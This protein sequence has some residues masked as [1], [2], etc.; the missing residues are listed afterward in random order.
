MPKN[1]SS[2]RTAAAAAAA[3]AAASPASH[4]WMNDRMER[5]IFCTRSEKCGCSAGK[6]RGRQAHG[7]ACS[8]SARVPR[9]Q[10]A[11]AR[12]DPSPDDFSRR[13]R[14]IFRGCATLGTQGA[15]RGKNY[16]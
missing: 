13:Q 3:A 6:I 14:R 16:S 4:A 5:L 2:H 7:A 9:I 8:A 10:P 11:P 1:R 12:Q 15:R